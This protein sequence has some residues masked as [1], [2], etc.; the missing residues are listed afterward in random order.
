MR[1]N[2]GVFDIN[3]GC[4]GYIYGL[5]LAKSMISSGEAKNVLL[6]TADTYSK[7]IDPNDN[8][9]S[10]IFG[11]AATASLICCD[12]EEI[13]KGLAQPILEQIVQKD[14]LSCDLLGLKTNREDQ[15]Y[16]LWMA[17]VS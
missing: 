11:D 16:L 13:K 8:S 5:S 2:C 17:Q 10:T 1:E 4:T 15:N 6:V 3:Q 12:Q 7:L 14:L 9:V